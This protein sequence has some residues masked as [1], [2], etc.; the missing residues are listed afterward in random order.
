CRL[1]NPTSGI[2]S[3]GSR[4]IWLTR[5]DQKEVFVFGFSGRSRRASSVWAT[6]F[7]TTK[8]ATIGITS[9]FEKNKSYNVE[10]AE[11]RETSEPGLVRWLLRSRGRIGAAGSLTVG[12]LR[13]CNHR[14]KTHRSR[15]S[16]AGSFIRSSRREIYDVKVS[17][18]VVVFFVI[19]WF[20]NDKVAAGRYRQVMVL[21]FFDCPGLRQGV[22]DL[23]GLLHKGYIDKARV[24]HKQF[25]LLDRVLCRSPWRQDEKHVWFEVEQQGVQ[26][27]SEAEVFQVSNDDTAVVQRWAED[28]TRSTYL[29]NRSPSSAIGFKKP[30]DML[31]NMCFNESGKYKKTFIGSGIGTGSLQVLQGVEFEVEPHEDHTFEGATLS[32]GTIQL[33][34]R[35]QMCMC[36]ATVVENVV[37]TAMAI[38]RAIHQIK[39]RE[40]Y[41]A[42]RLLGIRVVIIRVVQTLLEGH[43]ILSPEGSLSRDCDVEKNGYGLM[44]LGCAECLKANLQHME[45]LLTTEAGYM[46]FT[47]AWKKKIWLKGL[48]TESRYYLRLVAGIATGALVKGGS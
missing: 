8:G 40:M 43:S 2:K 5:I 37:T 33:Q 46:T 6:R 44:I 24:F 11:T 31:G 17:G 28:T 19:F 18:L 42:W 4:V 36:S 47:E 20:L 15:I 39:K 9:M 27:N 48:L 29:V 26:G 30:I 21:E 22:E 14:L 34:R 25:T 23:R 1:S 13:N 12:F 10:R 7:S 38:T 45:A 3:S 41:L 35:H 16:P 32:M